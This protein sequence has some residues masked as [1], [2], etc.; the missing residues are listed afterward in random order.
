VDRFWGRDLE[1]IHR[2]ENER[3]MGVE[4][5]HGKAAQNV[6]LL[7]SQAAEESKAKLEAAAEA[8][9]LQYEE[10]ERAR[11]AYL[12]MFYSCK[13]SDE[14]MDYLWPIDVH[15]EGIFPPAPRKDWWPVQAPL[16]SANTATFAG[17]SAISRREPKE[18]RSEVFISTMHKERMKARKPV[19]FGLTKS[20]GGKKTKLRLSGPSSMKP[21][22]L[23][24]LN[25]S[26][27]QPPMQTPL[28]SSS[29][30]L[31]AAAP[32]APQHPVVS[33]RSSGDADVPEYFPLPGASKDLGTAPVLPSP[34]P[35]KEEALWKQVFDA[36]DTAG[37]GYVHGS[38]VAKALRSSSTVDLDPTLRLILHDSDLVAA[39]Q[40][41]ETDEPAGFSSLEWVE[42]CDYAR[43]LGRWNNLKL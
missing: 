27:S 5:A 43:D 18:V 7:Q 38:D 4:D 26:P 14:V 11:K 34:A 23:A 17:S 13:S 39:L 8:F 1:E 22:D 21:R 28:S 42:F 25:D 15:L 37:T 32:S 31:P 19:S 29:P 30:A 35:S 3:L 41:I 40:T 9:R 6:A 33:Y 10:E 12:K 36:A 16:K 24:P 20:S 2:R